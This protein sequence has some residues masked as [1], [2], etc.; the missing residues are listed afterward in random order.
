MTV[1]DVDLHRKWSDELVT[2]LES[3][4]FASLEDEKFWEIMGHPEV[5]Q[6]Q[7]FSLPDVPWARTL[8]QEEA[9][10]MGLDDSSFRPGGAFKNKRFWAEVTGGNE[11]LMKWVTYGYSVYVA[12][13]KVERMRAEHG[14]AVVTEHADFVK[15]EIAKLVDMGAVEDITRVARSP[16]EARCVLSLVVAVNGE[17]KRRLC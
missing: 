12:D 14:N 10:A 2:T 5:Q 17:G 9:S 15:A 11:V 4:D 6:F 8:S 1:T 13:F 3:L 16:D 7:T